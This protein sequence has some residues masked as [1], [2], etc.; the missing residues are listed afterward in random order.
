MKPGASRPRPSVPNNQETVEGLRCIITGR[1]RRRTRRHCG[2]PMSVQVFEL[3]NP[4]AAADAAAQCVVE[5]LD[6]ALSVREWATLAISGGS[7]PKI[8][9]PKLAAAPVRWD[10]VHL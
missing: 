1:P 7:A 2:G 4:E 5:G 9:F 8:L 10:R 6:E 3:S